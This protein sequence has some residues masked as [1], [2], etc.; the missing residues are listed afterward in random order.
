MI[1]V[2]FRMGRHPF[3]NE[4]VNYPPAGVRYNEARLLTTRGVPKGSIKYKVKNIA[5][6]AYNRLSGGVNAIPIRCK[7]ELIFS[8][9]GLLVKS[10]KPWVTDVEQGYALVGYRQREKNIESI[11]RKTVL[12][13]R[14]HNCKILPWSFAAKKSIWS[15][16]H[17]KVIEDKIEVVYP[18]MHLEMDE[19]KRKRRGSCTFLYVNR[20]FYGKSGYETIK[21]F[22][23]IS[24]R[25]DA[26]L[27]FVSNTPKEVV[28][29]FRKNK[30][31]NFIEAPIPR[32]QVLELYKKS[33]V[34][35]LPTL[36]DCFGVVFL[37]AM[38]AGLP[39]I[40]TNIFA[41]PEIV[42][43]EKTGLLVNTEVQLY[44]KGYLFAFPSTQHLYDYVK[45]NPLKLLIKDLELKMSR[46]IEKRN[47]RVSFGR[48]G[49]LLVERGKFSIEHRN[50]KL[51][52]I[53]EELLR[54]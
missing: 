42:L 18:A 53:Y 23:N 2:Y 11:K 16:F 17:T 40:A 28:D 6:S 49:R 51:K 48:E 52:R 14:K 44:D 19:I 30:K 32:E 34:F 4:I 41:V 24:K 22:D 46:L 10:E 25:Y 33:D 45:K 37:E 7:D 27:I 21:A 36:F 8:V 3:Y 54:R 29:K 31:I 13:I 20:N 12:F 5:F 26:N 35:V 39:I 43:N 15:L 47:E 38:A 50:K 9:G 1:S